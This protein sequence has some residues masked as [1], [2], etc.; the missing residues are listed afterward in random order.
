MANPGPHNYQPPSAEQLSVVSPLRAGV[1]EDSAGPPA[2]RGCA[3]RD[4]LK[5]CL[6]LQSSG[7]IVSFS[8]FQWYQQI[9]QFNCLPFGLRSGPRGQSL[10]QD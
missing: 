1:I 3:D 2:A 8:S 5:R 9:S 6:F 4:R 7:S 10:H